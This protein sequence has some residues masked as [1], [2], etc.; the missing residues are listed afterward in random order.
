MQLPD[1]Q[2]FFPS[3]K[4]AAVLFLLQCDWAISE[5]LLSPVT[6]RDIRE[7]ADC[8]FLMFDQDMTPAEMLKDDHNYHILPWGDVC[9]NGHDNPSNICE[10]KWLQTSNVLEI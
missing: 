2:I 10:D 4:E 5:L 7:V 3:H 6:G 8:H 9:T 1:N